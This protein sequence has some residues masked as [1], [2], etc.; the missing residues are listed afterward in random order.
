MDR[1]TYTAHAELGATATDTAKR[2][3]RDAAA[4]A[5][6]AKAHALLDRNRAA[7]SGRQ[8][9]VALLAIL[10]VVAVAFAVARAW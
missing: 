7:S 10:D 3:R 1:N 9:L 6:L 2:L 5:S 4:A 8:R